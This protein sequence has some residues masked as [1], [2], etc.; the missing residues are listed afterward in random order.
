M[1]NKAFIFLIII[2]AV[3]AGGFWYL[4]K[5]IRPIED[6]STS[7]VNAAANSFR[8]VPFDN[9]TL[10][11]PHSPFKGEASAKVT[12]V[13]FLDPEC[14]ACAAM[15]PYVKKVMQE[16]K[17]DLRI[18]VRYMAYHKNS[19]YV[20]NILEGARAENKYWEALDL[21]FTTQNQWANHHNP[22]PELIPQILKPLG[23]NIDKIIADA[24]SG[25]FDHLVETDMKDGDVVGVRG[26]PTFF[27]NGKMLE[28]LG[29]E[30]LRAGI[31]KSI[32]P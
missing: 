23:L 32:N 7:Q 10:I 26:T 25:K 28:E 9:D 27:I 16:F 30:T 17:N 13:E 18:V 14:E 5:E 24:K 12:M 15:Y 22:R 1:K 20:V 6:T 31:E 21:L 29:Y 2:V 19:K 11:K 4:K 3:L 8:V